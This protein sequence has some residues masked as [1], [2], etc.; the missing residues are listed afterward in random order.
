MPAL[1]ITTTAPQAQR[2]AT[3]LGREMNYRNADGTYRDATASE[4]KEYV[5]AMLRAVVRNQEAAIAQQ[6]IVITPFDPT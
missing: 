1:T 3:A 6:Q 2:L 5:V 4:I